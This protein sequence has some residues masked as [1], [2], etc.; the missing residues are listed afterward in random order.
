MYQS[1]RQTA[2][3]EDNVEDTCAEFDRLCTEINVGKL[4]REN[5]LKPPLR[6]IVGALSRA[7]PKSAKM[8]SG[9]NVKKKK[10]VKKEVPS[11]GK[12][13]VAGKGKP[14]D[15]HAS[16]ARHKIVSLAYKRG[17]RKAEVGGAHPKEAKEAGRLAPKELGIEWDQ[18]HR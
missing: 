18:Q 9:K 5:D 3:V 6:A 12:P 1:T 8:Y 14:L 2:M 4:L 17:K 16:Y 13:K 15:P 7:L 11:N 10:K